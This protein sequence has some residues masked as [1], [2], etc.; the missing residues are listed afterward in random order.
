MK[1]KLKYLIPFIPIIGIIIV[2][3]GNTNSWFNKDKYGNFESII[4]DPY[5]L[6]FSAFWQGV[7]PYLIITKC[8]A[9]W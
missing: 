8:L 4:D 7:S 3:W 2:L 5:I 1:Y 9:I 6:F